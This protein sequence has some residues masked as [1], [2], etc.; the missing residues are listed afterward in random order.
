MRSDVAF[1]KIRGKNRVGLEKAVAR[2]ME[3]IHWQDFIQGKSLF[4]KINAMCDY[5]VPG[6]NTSPWFFEAVLKEIRK[7]YPKKSI[8]FGDCDLVRKEQLNEAVRNWGYLEIARKYKVGFIHLSTQSTKKMWVGPVFRKIK[9]PEV[10]LTVDDIITLPVV[11]THCRTTITGALKNQWGFTPRGIRDEFHPK[12]DKAIP[13]INKFFKNIRLALADMSISIEGS[14]PLNGAPKV[15]N[16]VLASSD[17][18]AL[19]TVAAKYMGFNPRK[20][21]H[22]VNSEK[23]GIGY[24]KY[25]ILGHKFKVNK[26]KPPVG[27][28]SYDPYV[29][30]IMYQTGLKPATEKIC[31]KTFYG[32]QFTR[33]VKTNKR[34]EGSW[35]E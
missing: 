20:I 22:I 1:V 11:K 33:L 12:L 17:R 10:L 29:N 26:F 21:G 6:V 35:N 27:E 3:L 24:I 31:R 30:S 2:A 16:L 15:C 19:D 9:V 14:G 23:A 18:V 13:E 8:F 7:A 5:V 28:V 32:K 4:L 34:V 25:R